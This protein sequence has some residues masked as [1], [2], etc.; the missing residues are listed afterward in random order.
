MIWQ[1]KL[2]RRLKHH[3][4]LSENLNLSLFIYFLSFLASTSEQGFEK[5]EKKEKKGRKNTGTEE[6]NH[7]LLD[8]NEIDPTTHICAA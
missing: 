5:T 4:G 3:L 7:V 6:R 2:P 8:Q 1:V